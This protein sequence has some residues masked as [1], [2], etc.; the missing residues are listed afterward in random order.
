VGYIVGNA[1]ILGTILLYAI[2]YVILVATVFSICAISTNGAVQVRQCQQTNISVFKSRQEKLSPMY[3]TGW[4][5]D[6]HTGP[7]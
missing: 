5:F 4:L 3:Q 7:D 1:G 2:A 6:K